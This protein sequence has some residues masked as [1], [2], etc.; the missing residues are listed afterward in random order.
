MIYGKLDNGQMF[1]LDDD[2]KLSKLGDISSDLRTV[3]KI[4][5]NQ[6]KINDKIKLCCISKSMEPGIV[7]YISTE[8][9]G[10]E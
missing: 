5:A 4:K 6:I 10:D 1:C 7:T 8:S 3:I 9:F 2:C